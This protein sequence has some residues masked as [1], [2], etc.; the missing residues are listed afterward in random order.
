MDDK[1]EAVN[2]ELAVPIDSILRIMGICRA[3]FDSKWRQEMM[4]CGAIFKVR[5]GQPPREYIMAFP[6]RVR[7]FIGHVA[8]RGD[9][10]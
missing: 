10:L 1:G 7:A 5:K 8:A 4:Q 6:S 2:F 9:I 3:K